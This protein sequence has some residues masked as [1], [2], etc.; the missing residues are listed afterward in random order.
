M[1]DD[2]SIKIFNIYDLSFVD[3]KDIYHNGKDGQVYC[4]HTKSGKHYIYAHFE[5][6]TKELFY[7]GLGRYNRCNHVVNRNQYWK[8]IR[9]KH[10]VVIK[11]LSVNLTA[12]EAAEKEKLFIS[13]LSP[14]SNMTS[15]GELYYENGKVTKVYAY[16]KDGS[17][18]MEFPSISSANIFFNQNEN[19]SRINRCL[20]NER[21]SFKEFIWRAEY[22]KSIDPYKKT[23][24][25]NQRCVY[26]YDLD[27]N[28]IEKLEKIS[29]FKEGSRAGISNVLD[30]DYVCHNSFWRST[31][32]KK[33]DTKKITPALKESI[34]V[35]NGRVFMYVPIKSTN[36]N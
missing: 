5:K 7:I 28:F 20:K 30:K 35:K 22:F 36:D 31:Y 12:E 2:K 26:R 6:D 21:K 1:A 23:K 29:D 3:P 33:I 13:Q 16:N 25:H 17:F 27:G 10:G 9:N 11:F 32:A 4:E 19:D 8:N 24:I 15:G 34:K 18:Y 14:K